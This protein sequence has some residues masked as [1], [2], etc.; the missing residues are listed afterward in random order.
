VVAEVKVMV[1]E[2]ERKMVVVVAKV[3]V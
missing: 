3:S 1:E 2:W